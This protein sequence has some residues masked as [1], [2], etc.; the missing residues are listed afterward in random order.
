MQIHAVSFRDKTTHGCLAK[1]RKYMYV[2]KSLKILYNNYS[3]YLR[4]TLSENLTNVDKQ[5]F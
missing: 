2:G 1:T 3:W 4:S 5:K